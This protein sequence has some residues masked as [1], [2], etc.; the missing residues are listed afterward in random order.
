MLRCTSAALIG[1]IAAG[2]SLPDR[3]N[4][5]DPQNR[6]V[7]ALEIS[8]GAAVP[9]FGNRLTV[10]LLDASES[11]TPGSETFRFDL[12]GDGVFET[13]GGPCPTPIVDDR[14]SCL[15]A[16]LAIPAGILPG[17]VGAYQH[18]IAVQVGS[19]S[20]S[21]TTTGVVTIVNTAPAIPA[22]L[23]L[24]APARTNGP[25]R[26][27]L[28]A[29]CDTDPDGEIVTWNWTLLRGDLEGGQL[30]DETTSNARIDAAPWSD[31]TLVF[32]ADANDGLATASSLVRVHVTTQAWATSI[33]P[34]RVYR[35]FPDFRPLA[36]FLAELPTG[37][38]AEDG[39]LFVDGGDV[40]M[41]IGVLDSSYRLVA[42]E[43]R[44]FQRT[45]DGADLEVVTT[46]RVDGA[47]AP[48]SIA[49]A[50]GVGCAAFRTHIDPTFE[51]GFFARLEVNGTVTT[52]ASSD[53][54]LEEPAWVFPANATDCWAATRRHPDGNGHANLYRLLPDAS[55]VTLPA[56]AG[57]E[58][59]DV[60]AATVAADG[61]L[62][63]AGETTGCPVQSLSR[64]SSLTAPA[65][66]SFC[67][68]DGPFDQLVPGPGST[69]WAHDVTSK[70]TL[71]VTT[72]G[73]A[74]DSGAPPLFLPPSPGAYLHDDFFPE[75][76]PRMAYDPVEHRLWAIDVGQGALVRLTEIDG[77]LTDLRTLAGT[78]FEVLGGGLPSFTTV[79][80]WPETGRMLTTVEGPDSS[81]L[82]QVPTHMLR[83]EEVFVSSDFV[84][85]SIDASSGD[86]WITTGRVGSEAYRVGIDGV[87]SATF[88]LPVG[89][90]AWGPSALPDGGAW[91]AIDNQNGTGALIRVDGNGSEVTNIAHDT[92]L[93]RVDTGVD[94]T[95]CA[96]GQ[97][98]EQDQTA[99]LLRLL[100]GGTPEEIPSPMVSGSG[101]PAWSFPLGLASAGGTCWTTFVGGVSSVVHFDDAV[102]LDS[103]FG[104]NFTFVDVDP[105]TSLAWVAGSGEYVYTIDAGGSIFNRSMVVGSG[106]MGGV[107]PALVDAVA[108]RRSCTSGVTCDDSAPLKIWMI[109]G[110]NVVRYAEDGTL[111]STYRL[112]DFSTTGDFE[113]LP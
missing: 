44:R 22:E 59:L 53:V 101:V 6:A 34:N 8:G 21:D 75:G 112:P 11:K 67:R 60:T 81:I 107:L 54:L 105:A 14:S 110:G 18:E 104:G 16:T 76:E 30:L 29:D 1:L 35:V 50:G 99:D 32:R 98:S 74:S 52:G 20:A 9:N 82:G 72:S 87:P 78:A 26:L 62:W 19:G 109:V 69:I 25:V 12:D 71:L 57:G 10:F 77:R 70:K 94:G 113:V 73:I 63:V 41:G 93:F 17:G 80:L 91:L 24:F 64:V 33:L 3:N 100:P 27:D 13:P 89:S 31:Q 2:C 95:V 96:V 84:N 106:S 46:W 108:V 83:V 42:G 61:S 79:A 43:V 47:F 49:A 51:S 48:T 56:F 15:Q 103:T 68:T 58:L 36:Q 85:V 23:D 102:L 4:P 45:P 40:W 65:A 97:V 66:Q 28:C 37:Y 38:R 7:A 111:E 90:R 88:A 5:R 92:P 55:V 86:A 39:G